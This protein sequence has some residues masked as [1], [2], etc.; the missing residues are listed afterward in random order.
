MA[1]MERIFMHIHI[2]LSFWHFLVFLSSFASSF[3]SSGFCL[4]LVFK[5]LQEKTFFATT[6]VVGK[7]QKL[8]Q[9]SFTPTT[10][11]SL[12]VVA[13]SSVAKS[14]AAKFYIVTICNIFQRQYLL[15]F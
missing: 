6:K 14:F 7:C 2:L 15:P 4:V 8:L 9:K 5:V 10:K 12:L 13:I 1:T 11:K 3:T